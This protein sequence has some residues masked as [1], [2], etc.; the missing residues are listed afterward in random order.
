MI[1]FKA[2]FGRKTTSKSIARSRLHFVLVQDRTG[3]SNDDLANFK[4]EMV[5]VIEKYFVI[6]KQGFDIDY[7]RE[8]DLTT[9]VINSPIVV[10]RQEGPKHEVGAKGHLAAKVEKVEN[11][12]KVEGA[13]GVVASRSEDSGSS[14][15]EGI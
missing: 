8:S 2:L 15:G 3:L 13:E 7:K 5:A 10:R 12:D 6:D 11:S 14:A 9:L 1:D 4:H